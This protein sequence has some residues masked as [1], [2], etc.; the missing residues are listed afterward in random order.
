MI[1]E[2]L[3]KTCFGTSVRPVYKNIG[4]AAFQLSQVPVEVRK[5]LLLSHVYF[6]LDS[7]VIMA[8]GMWNT[9][10]LRQRAVIQRIW[11]FLK[12]KPEFIFLLYTFLVSYHIRRYASWVV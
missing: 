2:C 7:M 8:F 10:N 6:A 3:K 4:D 5:S 12:I 9:F 1:Y 11:W